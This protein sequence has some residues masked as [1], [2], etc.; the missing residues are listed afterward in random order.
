MAQL[1]LPL[2]EIIELFKTKN[3]FPL[4]LGVLLHIMRRLSVLAG[5][6]VTINE[7]QSL[8]FMKNNSCTV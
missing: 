4:G 3:S 6:L 5:F 2:A 7:V 1:F 8:S